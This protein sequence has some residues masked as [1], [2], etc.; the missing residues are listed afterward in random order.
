MKYSDIQT[1]I[2]LTTEF[3]EIT[4]FQFGGKLCSYSE[5]DVGGT[6]RDRARHFNGRVPN[7]FFS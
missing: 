3:E 6:D 2:N 5:V 7:K 1:H 4:S